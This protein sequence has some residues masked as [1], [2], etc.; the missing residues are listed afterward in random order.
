MRG[1]GGN[2]NEAFDFASEIQRLARPEANLGASEELWLPDYEGLPAS[3]KQR[4]QNHRRT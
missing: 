1:V 2:R 3:E 4:E